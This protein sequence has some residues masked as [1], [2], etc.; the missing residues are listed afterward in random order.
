MKIYD[1][2]YRIFRLVKMN[3]PWRRARFRREVERDM[4]EEARIQKAWD[5]ANVWE[6]LEML[7]A[8]DRGLSKEKVKSLFRKRDDCRAAFTKRKDI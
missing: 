7:A 8:V 5:N 3:T 6:A 2:M 1:R 4:A